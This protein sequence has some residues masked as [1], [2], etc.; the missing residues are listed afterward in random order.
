MSVKGLRI[1]DSEDMVV[2]IDLPQMLRLVDEGNLLHWAILYVEAT[3]H[4]GEGLSILDFENSVNESFSGLR[5]SWQRLGQLSHRFNQVID[6]TIIGCRDPNILRRYETD[7]EMYEACDT[8]IRMIDSS[9]WEIHSK[10][11]NLIE[12]CK[13]RFKQVVEL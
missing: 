13:A 2:S 4:L 9:Y 10:D 3:G 7:Q 11:Q 5:I 8:V 1:L 6:I 12:R